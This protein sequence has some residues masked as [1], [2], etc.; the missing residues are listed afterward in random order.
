MVYCYLYG[1]ISIDYYFQAS[2]NLK[3][4]LYMFKIP[5]LGSLNTGVED[6]FLRGKVVKNSSKV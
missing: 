1:A 5:C 4:I 2:F 6:G 3:I